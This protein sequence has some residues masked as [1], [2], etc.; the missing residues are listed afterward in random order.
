VYLDDRGFFSKITWGDKLKAERESRIEAFSKKWINKVNFVYRNSERIGGV[1]NVQVW[2]MGA[3]L[4]L[5]SDNTPDQCFSDGRAG[6]S[7]NNI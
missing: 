1:R 5:G 2:A 6:L 7:D 3:L 4:V